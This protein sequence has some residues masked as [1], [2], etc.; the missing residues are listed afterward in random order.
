MTTKPVPAAAL[1]VK[2]SHKPLHLFSAEQVSVKS[3]KLVP[4]Q[5]VDFYARPRVQRYAWRGAK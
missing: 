2:L 4:I 1:V 3:V 5:V